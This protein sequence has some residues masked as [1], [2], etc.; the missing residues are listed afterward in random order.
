MKMG[1]RRNYPYLIHVRFW[2]FHIGFHYEMGW[3]G[4]W[5]MHI[6]VT[7]GINGSNS[8]VWNKQGFR[9]SYSRWVKHLQIRIIS[10]CRTDCDQ[11]LKF[12][13]EISKSF[14]C[15]KMC[16]QKCRE[17]RLIKI[18]MTKLLIRW[19]HVACCHLTT[20]LIASEK[21]LFP[22]S[23]MSISIAWDVSFFLVNFKSSN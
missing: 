1:V 2:L 18:T 12:V 9:T 13:L 20:L 19:P 5:S 4:G 11:F 6:V 7:N 16:S 23:S 10:I 17:C 15:V 14:V 3:R 22:L 8:I 21:N